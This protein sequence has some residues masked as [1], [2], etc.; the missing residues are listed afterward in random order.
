MRD[1]KPWFAA[2]DSSRN[3]TANGARSLS[4]EPCS[5]GERGY[6]HGIYAE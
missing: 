1:S 5:T 3:L 4:G 6:T 2:S